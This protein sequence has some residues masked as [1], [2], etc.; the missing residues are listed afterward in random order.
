MN[1]VQKKFGVELP[2]NVIYVGRP[3]KW[4]NPFKIGK[5]GTR[6]E[7]VAKYETWLQNKLAEDYAFLS[8]LKGHDIACWCKPEELCHADII[9]KYVEKY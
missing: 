4:G 7:V 1:R 6:E 2:S 8:E 9:M 5:H 3:S